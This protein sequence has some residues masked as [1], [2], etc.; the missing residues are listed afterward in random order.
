MNLLA[1]VLFTTVI[2][3][4]AL[5]A[6][7]ATED[8][9]PRKGSAIT[10]IV[11][12]GAGGMIDIL[13]RKMSRYWDQKWGTQ[14]VVINK[15]GAAG[16]LGLAEMLKQRPDG[17]TVAFAHGFDTHMTYLDASTNAPYSRSS[18]AFPGLAQRTSEVWV[19]R[20]DSPFQTVEQFIAAAKANPGKL[21][22]GSTSSRSTVV[23]YAQRLKDRG[24]PVTLVPYK[25]VPSS[26]NALLAGDLD[27]TMSN[28]AV[29]YP[30]YKAEKIRVLLAVGSKPSKYY[31][32]AKT[33]DDLKLDLPDLN[34]TGVAL[35]KSTPP[36]VVQTWSAMLKEIASDPQM[37]AD[38]DAMAVNLDYLPPDDYM[39]LWSET[40]FYAQKV[41]E[42]IGAKVRAPH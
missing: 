18:F 19:V 31:P 6:Q 21:N 3:I 17:Y 4:A 28:A 22:F 7:S 24:A 15:P 37:R 42:S 13:A 5:S 35:P 32:D 1:R 33:S 41:L 40:E 39:K 25:D 2:S 14:S 16:Q 8:A 11:P 30:Y 36:A 34:Y 38:L 23:I 12:W 29:A 10:V 27:I 9:F 26:M 20:A